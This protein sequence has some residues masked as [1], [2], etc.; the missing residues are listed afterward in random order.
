VG[1][2][3]SG[4]LATAGNG[5]GLVKLWDVDTGGLLVEFRTDRIDGPA[6]ASPWLDFSP[7]GSFLLYTDIGGIL[8]RYIMD[9][10]DLI[11]LA[12]GRLTRGFTEDECVIH[13]T[14]ERCEELGL[15]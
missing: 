1:I 10:D 11:E 5:D 7:D 3:A 2:T 8:R 13:L 14:P 15:G 4:I 12:E 6:V 9:T